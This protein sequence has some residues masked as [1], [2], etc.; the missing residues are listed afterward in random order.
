[1]GPGKAATFE[2]HVS[3]WIGG[4]PGA[5]EY[6]LLP[7]IGKLGDTPVLCFYG[8]EEG[9]SLCREK[10]PASV[11]PIVLSGG[12]HFDGRYNVII[13]RILQTLP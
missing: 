3:D 8:W 10:L 7:E 5:A 2:F 11:T 12:H 6:P 13:D 4:G 1:M 9:N